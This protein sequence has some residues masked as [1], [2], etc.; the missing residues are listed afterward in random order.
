MK[1]NVGF[2]PQCKST[3]SIKLNKNLVTL[4]CKCDL[5]IELDIAN[6][7]KLLE[8]KGLKGS[9]KER[10]E[11][12]Y[13]KDGYEHL[14][15]YFLTLRNGMINYLVKQINDV[16]TAYEESYKRNVNTLKL[17]TIFVDNYNDDPVMKDNIIHMNCFNYAKCTLS[18]E[19]KEVIK[20]YNEYCVLKEKSNKLFNYFEIKTI[21]EDYNNK[22]LKLN[23]NRICHYGYHRESIIYDP[24][25][26]YNIVERIDAHKNAITMCQLD[27]GTIVSATESNSLR[28]GNFLFNNAHNAQIN[29]LIPLPNNIMASCSIDHTVKIWNFTSPSNITLIKTMTEH[30]SDVISILYIKE[31]DIMISVGGDNKLCLWNMSTLKCEKIIKGIDNCSKNS[32]YKIDNDRIFVGRYDNLSILN[33]T[34]MKIEKTI[35]FNDCTTLKCFIK[36]RD[37]IILCGTAAGRFLVYNM[38]TKKSELIYNN[39]LEDVTNFINI[40]EHTFMSCS[41]DSIKV[42]KY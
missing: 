30:D 26:D 2:C 5:Q 31:R 22:L 36:L 42:W 21:K 33:I 13:I 16:E 12:S 39:H 40:D 1:P 34:K 17:V 14:N 27:D 10:K 41:E 4:K 25:K 7:L 9:S 15:E 37:N 18:T 32:L 20:F 38:E 35:K 24:I 6:Y 19:V 8:S 28:F 29:K 11:L 23:D 3:P